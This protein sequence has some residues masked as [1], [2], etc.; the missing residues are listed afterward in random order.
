MTGLDYPYRPSDGTEGAL[1]MAKFCAA[2]S[3]EDTCQIWVTTMFLDADDPDYPPEWVTS[4]HK[5]SPPRT[6][7]CTAFKRGGYQEYVKG[8]EADI[9]SGYYRAVDDPAAW[10]GMALRVQELE[11]S[12]S[13]GRE[14]WLLASNRV[15]ELEQAQQEAAQYIDM[16][17]REKGKGEAVIEWF[18]RESICPAS[19]LHVGPHSFEGWWED[20]CA[21]YD[22]AHPAEEET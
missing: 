13:A 18:W 7:R 20:L 6:A 21:Q 8:V 1:F 16:L 15:I 14:E 12:L 2:C 9:S 10:D 22:A 5:T 19:A 4:D 11:R 3:R 17:T